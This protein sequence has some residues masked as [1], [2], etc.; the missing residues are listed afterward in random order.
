[1]AIYAEVTANECIIKRH[2]RIIGASLICV[3]AFLYAVDLIEMDLLALYG[4]FVCPSLRS[5]H[6]PR[7]N[8]ST[9]ISKCLLH[10]TTK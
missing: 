3:G 1:M 6:D 5:T 4:L 8:A 7:L 10:C 2:L 9:V